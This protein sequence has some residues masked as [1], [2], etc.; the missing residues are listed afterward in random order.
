MQ[1]GTERDEIQKIARIALQ[2]GYGKEVANSILACESI[3]KATMI[4][5]ATRK[6][7]K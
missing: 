1:G 7:L 2:L 6:S 5:T 4:M 3:V